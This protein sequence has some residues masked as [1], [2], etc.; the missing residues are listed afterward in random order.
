MRSS[1]PFITGDIFARYFMGAPGIFLTSYALAAGNSRVRR[2]EEAGPYRYIS[3]SV[4]RRFWSTGSRA[5]WSYPQAVFSPRP[6][7]ITT[8]SRAVGVPVQVIRAVCVIVFTYGLI[9]V[10]S[11]FEWQAIDSI[12]KAHAI[13]DAHLAAIV[14]SSEDAII[15]SNDQGHHHELE[16]GRGKD[17][18]LYC[19]GNDRPHRA[20][21]L[22]PPDLPNELP[23]HYR[24][25]R[26]GR[27]HPFL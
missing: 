1:Q 16:Q 23:R 2:A 27:K 14:E 19:R 9:K 8:P 11:I 22:I 25:G 4:Q 12:Q 26:A 21:V 13:K 15:G 18:R 10:L 5:A 17:L 6:F 3:R 7:L 24:K 20:Q